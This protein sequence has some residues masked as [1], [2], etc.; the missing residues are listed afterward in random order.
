MLTGKR[1]LGMKVKRNLHNCGEQF[2]FWIEVSDK[3]VKG[4]G[5]R[6]SRTVVEAS[7]VFGWSN[8]FL[9]HL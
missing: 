9:R 6:L 7:P 1:A 5:G 4:I 3:L 2:G 8:C